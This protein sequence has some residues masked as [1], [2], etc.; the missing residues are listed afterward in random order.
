MTDVKH[1]G[2]L[3]LERALKVL[4]ARLRRFGAPFFHL[5]FVGRL[6][7]RGSRRFEARP[8]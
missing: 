4:N 8:I 7:W 1:T 3:T 5:S 2:T 6:P